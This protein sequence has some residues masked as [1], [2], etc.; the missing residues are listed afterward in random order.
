MHA[1]TTQGAGARPCTQGTPHPRSLGSRVPTRSRTSA[2]KGSIIG[3]AWK[4]HVLS[5]KVPVPAGAHAVVEAQGC[6]ERHKE[7]C[8]IAHRGAQRVGRLPVRTT[9]GE[10]RQGQQACTRAAAT[11][12]HAST[13]RVVCLT[14]GAHPK[15]IGGELANE[16]I[17][18][19]E[20]ERL[21][22]R[23]PRLLLGPRRLQKQ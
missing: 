22:A 11:P 15:E 4:A 9:T 23:V 19:C 14:T 18:A 17:G 3:A 10:R 6:I 21:N 13:Q 8:A 1:R 20:K 5:R 2:L 12:C 16:D 7:R